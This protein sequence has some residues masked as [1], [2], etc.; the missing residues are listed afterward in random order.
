[1][2]VQL[3]TDR[4]PMTMSSR[5]I[6]DLVERRHDN[7]KRTVETLADRGVIEFPQIE[8]IPTAT[9]PTTVFH[10]AKRDT[11]V[12]VAQL[13]PEFTARLVDRWQ[14]L[15]AQA[16][17][18][19]PDLSDPTVLTGLLLEHAAKR[20]EAEQRADAAEAKVDAMQ[21]D[22]EA[23]HRLT[24]ADGSLTGTEAAKSLGI[25]PKELFLWLQTHGWI[26]RRPGSATWLGFQR[27]CNDGLLIHR[28]TTV[29]R[30]DGT[31][32]ICEQVRITPKG[33]AT[34]AKVIRPTAKLIVEN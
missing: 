26:Y 8:E 19:I 9:K 1:M 31:E 34:L 15:E 24:A 4:A 7:V 25:A 28:V 3:L 12:V 20:I 16:K 29:L 23:H 2:N 17:P 22:V 32:R 14:E 5:E 10:L 13:S 21:S 27:R 18:T 30:P 33:L 11:F 6:A